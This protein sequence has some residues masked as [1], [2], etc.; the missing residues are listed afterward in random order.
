MIKAVVGGGGKGMR[1]VQEKEDFVAALASVENEARKAFGDSRVMLECFVKKPRHI[2][3]Q[4]LGDQHG[5]ILH[6]FESACSP[7]SNKCKLVKN[8]S[9]YRKIWV[10]LV[11]WCK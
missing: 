4:V 11:I 3:F 7:L 6:L 8:G 2:E 1:V 5:N 10:L 9:V